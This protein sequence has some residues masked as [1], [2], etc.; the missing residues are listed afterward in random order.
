MSTAN[1]VSGRV[2]YRLKVAQIAL[3]VRMD[4]ALKPVGITAPQYAVLTAIA[5][6]PGVSNAALARAAFVTPQTMQ[7]IVAN[8]ERMGLLTR[9][10][11]PSLGRI[12]RADLTAKGRAALG[13]AHALVTDVED[14]M[15]AGL[16]KADTARLADLLGRCA[17]NLADG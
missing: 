5:A 6:E 1:D 15:L 12:L 9:S 11:H 14:K 17:D 3:R 13:R 4:A 8:L 7:G 2:G 16:S 10:E